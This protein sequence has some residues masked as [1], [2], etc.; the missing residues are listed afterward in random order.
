MWLRTEFT[1]ETTETK[2]VWNKEKTTAQHTLL[3]LEKISF[4]DEG[5][6]RT[7]SGKR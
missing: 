3:N 7:I 6:V 2:K 4:R 1:S 5:N